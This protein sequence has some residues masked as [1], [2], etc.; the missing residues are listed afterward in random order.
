MQARY[1]DPVIGRFYSNDPIGA[2]S[3]L[4]ATQGVQGF[5]RYSYVNNN[6]YKYTDPT[7]MCATIEDESVRATCEDKRDKAVEEAKE[8]LKKVRVRRGSKEGAFISTFDE[9]T[10]KINTRKGNEAGKRSNGEVVFTDSNGDELEAMSN[11]DG[12]IIDSNEIILVT[13]HSHPKENKKTGSRLNDSR[14]DRKNQE[15][16]GN[17]DDIN[18][19]RIA[20]AVIKGPDG[21]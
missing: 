20:P 12:R 18:L 5:N 19:S 6:P 10:Q 21:I 13:G 8:Y 14:T 16:V 1:Y 9:T 17:T 11:E 2:V 15:I 3:H 7:G 4:S